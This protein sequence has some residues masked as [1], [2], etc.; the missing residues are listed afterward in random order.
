ME[1]LVKYL[2][3][4]PP[5][6]A[7]IIGAIAVMAAAVITGLKKRRK[8]SKP[9]DKISTGFRFGFYT[10]S[11][12][13]WI[14]IGAVQRLLDLGKRTKNKKPEAAGAQSTAGAGPTTNQLQIYLKQAVSEERGKCREL[15]LKLGIL[16]SA[17]SLIREDTTVDELPL[18]KSEIDTTV[19]ALSYEIKRSIEAGQLLG[20]SFYRVWFMLF[21]KEFARSQQIESNPSS[22][23]KPFV[24]EI[25]RDVAKAE[26]NFARA[27][28]ENAG[29]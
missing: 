20:S 27:G 26:W 3:A 16:F 13:F 1:A 15:A 5:V 17:D 7:A 9:Y 18:Y 23:V 12:F 21:A 8:R 28:Q 19:T 2:T 14:K 24:A 29:W 22:E 10:Y 11:L 25:R 4:N 6:V